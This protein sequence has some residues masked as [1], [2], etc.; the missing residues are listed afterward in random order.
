MNYWHEC[1]TTAFEELQLN[2]TQEQIDYIVNC[3]EGAHENYSLAMGHECIPNPL[4]AEVARLKKAAIEAKVETE[5]AFSDFRK[6][7]ARR[8]NVDAT[9]V[10]LEG[11]GRATIWI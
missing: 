6:N 3:V 1:I 10:V 4:G 11:G 5:K 7:V 9:S 8:H 2:A